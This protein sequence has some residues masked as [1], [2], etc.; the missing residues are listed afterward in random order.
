MGN[1]SGDPMR[2]V[3]IVVAE[4]KGKLQESRS[5]RGSPTSITPG[6]VC[7]AFYTDAHD[8]VS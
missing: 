6:A 3:R 8:H 1:I 4:Q 5:N 2:A 7:F